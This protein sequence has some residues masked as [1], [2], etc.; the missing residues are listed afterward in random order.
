MTAKRLEKI[1]QMSFDEFVREQEAN[2]LADVPPRTR[3]MIR[4]GLVDGWQ[5]LKVWHD[6]YV[7][8]ELTVG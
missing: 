5:I 4:G 7:N 6:G 3:L 2:D 1:R 8:S